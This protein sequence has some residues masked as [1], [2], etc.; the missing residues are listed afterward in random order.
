MTAVFEATSKDLGT[1]RRMA[2]EGK[3][4]D[5]I[6][7]ALGWNCTADATRNR[8]RQYQIRVVTRKL[9]HRGDETTA[10]P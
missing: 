1:A 10:S 5:E 4:I 6:H 8:L 2:R 7:D 3:S 9:A